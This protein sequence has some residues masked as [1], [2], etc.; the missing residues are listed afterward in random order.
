MGRKLSGRLGRVATV[1]ILVL[2]VGFACSTARAMAAPSLPSSDPFYAYT[3]ATP[4]G[5]MAPGTVLKQRAAQIVVNGAPTP[6]SARQVLYRTTGELGQ[7]TATVATVISPLAPAGPTKLVSYQTFYDALGSE[8][9]PS[10]TLQGGNPGYQD[11]QIDATLME[12]Y[13]NAGFTVVNADYEGESLDW[14]AGQESG[15]NT[16]DGIRAA[17]NA[18]KLPSSTDVGM[19]GYSGG[20]IATEWASELAPGYAPELHIIGAAEGGIPV[21]YAHN[22]TYINGDTDGWAG[23]IPAVLVGTARA[24]DLN[25]SQYLSAYGQ[26]VVNQV[27][28]ECINDFAGSYNGL[29]VQQ[30]LKPQYQD[31]LGVPTF[32]SIINTLTMGTSATHPDSPLFMAVGDADGT[33]D[34]VMVAADVEALAHEYCTK[35]VPVTFNEYSG[36]DHEE[37]I[38]P[39]ETAALAFLEDLFAGG[40]APNG[41]ASIGEGNSLALLPVAPAGSG[42]TGAGSAPGAS[43]PVVTGSLH[44]TTLGLVRLGM[45]RAQARHAYSHSSNRGRRYED[46]FCLTPIGVRVGYASPKLLGRMPRRRRG[47]YRGR[48]VWAS[49]SDVHFAVDGVRPGTTVR[50][51][52]R[53]IHHLG[54][55]FEV[56]LNDWYLARIAG[57]TAVL[58]VRHGVVE[59]IGIADLALTRTR[60]ADRIF[61]HSFY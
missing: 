22:L 13:L 44:R 16:L 57:A 58:K 21:D 32:A 42:S 52:R 55:P 54:M 30:L 48:I 12:D 11:A 23:V 53:M 47:R 45:T 33:G 51:A 61:V 49:T 15:E 31:F 34:D 18:L 24:F 28:S 27:S 7:P 9:D 5:Q 38:A 14:A 35:G 46:F 10:Y 50:A 20:S 29:T 60:A 19:V 3:G 37:A 26:Q 6:Y 56:G 1:A 36:A 17:E 59:E 2:A 8:C 40:P 25:L 39:F 4:L 43:C 41:C